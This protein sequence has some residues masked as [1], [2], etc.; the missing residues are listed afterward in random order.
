MAPGELAIELLP[1]FKAVSLS[2]RRWIQVFCHS[3]EREDSSATYFI[4]KTWDKRERRFPV[5]GF[6]LT[7]AHRLALAEYFQGFIFHSILID[8]PGSIYYQSHFSEMKR[9]KQDG[10]VA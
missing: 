6:L 1:L 10:E 3:R 9:V 4:V 5:D 8:T 7:P 2:H